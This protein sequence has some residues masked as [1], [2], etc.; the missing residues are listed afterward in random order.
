MTL[1]VFN[2]TPA[3]RAIAGLEEK[4]KYGPNIQLLYDLSS[5]HPGHTFAFSPIIP[6][7]LLIDT[8]TI[9]S[10]CQNSKILRVYPKTA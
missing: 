6:E 2:L 5:I 1:V 10:L 9:Y 7:S 3:M 4:V 8:T